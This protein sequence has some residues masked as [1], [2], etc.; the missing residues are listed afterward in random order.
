VDESW[1]EVHSAVREDGVDK[2]EV[3]SLM[4]LE[5]TIL[6]TCAVI[7]SDYL[8]FLSIPVVCSST[9]GSVD[10][11]DCFSEFLAEDVFLHDSLS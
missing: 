7:R 1:E 8:G 3:L 4:F 9:L 11:V 6:G 5:T 2:Y 10:E